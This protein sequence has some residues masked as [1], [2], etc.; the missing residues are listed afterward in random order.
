MTPGYHLVQLNAKTGVPVASFG[1]N[2]IVD[3][4]TE[5]D[6]PGIDLETSDI[7]LNSPPALGNNVS[8]LAPAV[9]VV[10]KLLKAFRERGLPVVHTKECH[11][12]DLADCPPAKPSHGHRP[13]DMVR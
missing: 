11:R 13:G 7:G 2:G 1:R 3:L 9:P 4:K 12:A 8:L 5:I 10:A 6:Q